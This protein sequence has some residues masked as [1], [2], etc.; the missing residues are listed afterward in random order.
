MADYLNLNKLQIAMSTLRLSPSAGCWR[1]QNLDT[2]SANKPPN[3]PLLSANMLLP[4]C[5]LGTQEEVLVTV[6]ERTAE[7]E[8]QSINKMYVLQL[9]GGGDL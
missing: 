1:C 3:F 7:S 9:P 6:K 5:I 4:L 2:N 8:V